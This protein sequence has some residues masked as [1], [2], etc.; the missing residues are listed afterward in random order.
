MKLLKFASQVYLSHW[1]EKL[2]SY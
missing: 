2:L 1:L